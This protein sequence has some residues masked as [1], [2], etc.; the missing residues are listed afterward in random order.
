MDLFESLFEN[1]AHASLVVGS[2]GVILRANLAAS[3][4]LGWPPD[5]LQRMTLAE[6][7]AERAPLDQLL[8]SGN[9]PDVV[10][11]EVM[12]RHA[13]D[14]RFPAEVASIAL[15][16]E[17]ERLTFVMFQDITAQRRA[18][19]NARLEAE[20]HRSFFE[21]LREAVAYMEPVRDANGMITTYFVVDANPPM[22]RLF[23][24]EDLRGLTLD[25]LATP[26]LAAQRNKQ[27]AKILSTGE[28]LEYETTYRERYIHVR[29]FKMA[30]DT[31]G[32]SV[33][34]LTEQKRSEVALADLFA[35]FDAFMETLPGLAWIKDSER[36]LIWVNK[37]FESR[38]DVSRE[39]WF[40]KKG[41]EVFPA[42]MAADMDEADDLIIASGKPH[43]LRTF[44][45]SADKS[46]QHW[47]QIV[48]FPFHDAEG[49][50]FF[51][52]IATEITPQK[53]AEDALRVSESR[54][55]TAYTEL[56][57]ALEV[58][59]RTEEKFRQSQKME[60]VGRLAGGIAHDF[61][62]LLTV[63]LGNAE[64]LARGLKNDTLFDEVSEIQ[65]A[66]KR[67]SELTRQ[68]LAFSRKQALE[69]R[70][71]NINS[72]V[73]ALRNMF[74]RLLGEDVE[75]ALLL[76]PEPFLCRVDP[77]Q[78]EQV[79]LNLIVNARDAMPNG[80]RLTIETANV[81]LD[82]DY[83]RNHPGA[84]AGPHLV[85]SISDNGMGMTKEVQSHLFEPFFTTKPVGRGT[86]LGLSTV[87]GIVKQSGGTIWV[88]SEPGQ[89]T[90]IKVYFPRATGLED[91]V[92]VRPAAGSHLH[93]SETVLLVEDDDKVRK[94]VSTILRRAGY[95]VMEAD[96]GGEA[97]LICEQHE[98]R[99]ALLLTDVVMPKLNGKQVAERLRA[100]RPGMRVIFMS[101][102]TENVVV[103]HGVV[104]SGVDFLQ[105]PLTAETLLPKVREV[106]DRSA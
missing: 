23:G 21:V 30:T 76:H 48:K 80:G 47:W 94:T 4:G 53:L 82:E 27:F 35:R 81:S 18:A 62:N 98:A 99:I 83:A 92:M 73:D 14:E 50:R 13:R 89:G 38:L 46:Q 42:Q 25:D 10:R 6:L 36:R 87:Y 105:K 9:R 69:P 102:Y 44:S 59:R 70:V 31:I 20:R 74:S 86:G 64:L 101:G 75:V 55:R 41:E 91:P 19:R 3:K 63:I 24:V 71:V 32:V 11:A 65:S 106:L 78:I 2:S 17:G 16:H 52:G 68:L 56:A 54:A 67:A 93:G 8:A 29:F 84:T 97:L 58:T 79:V 90:T 49:R 37:T 33:V 61:N 26:Q 45:E 100:I 85:L 39:R 96:N 12:L 95:H 57:D 43:S 104:D 66:G 103:H 88:Y 60:A 77:G 15:T 28:A 1:S 40:G 72:I 7:V 34:D 5:Q 51:G 22:H